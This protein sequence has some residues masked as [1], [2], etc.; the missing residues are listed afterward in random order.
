[1]GFKRPDDNQLITVVDDLSTVEG[2]IDRDLTF[3]GVPT[4]SAV[5]TGSGLS[6]DTGITHTNVKFTFGSLAV[7]EGRVASVTIKSKR[8]GNTDWENNVNIPVSTADIETPPANSFEITDTLEMYDSSSS[9]YDFSVDFYSEFNELGTLADLSPAT[10]TATVSFNGID[11]ITEL[12]GV[13]DLVCINLPD[14]D[15][16]GQSAGAYVPQDVIS[17]Q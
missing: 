16:N 12:V 5:E 13:K 8:T 10:K 4:L 14:A 17:L 9:S 11:D 15:Q 7:T 6:T 1:M 3:S 2:A